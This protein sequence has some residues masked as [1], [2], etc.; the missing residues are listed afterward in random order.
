MNM[1]RASVLAG[2]CIAAGTTFAQDF[3]GEDFTIGAGLEAIRDW[4]RSQLTPNLVKQGRPWGSPTDPWLGESSITLDANGWPTMDAGMVFVSNQ[5][6]NDGQEGTYKIRFECATIPEIRPIASYGTVENVVRDTNTGIVTADY[7]YPNIN[8]QVMFGF[9][10]TNGGVRNLTIFRP[11]QDEA[12][13]FTNLYR[14]HIDR[15]SVLRFMDMNLI[16]NNITAHWSQRSQPS[17]VTWRTKTGIPYENSIALCNQVNSDY[18]LCIPHRATDDYIRQLARLVRDNLNPNLKV[19][20]EMSNEVWNTIYRQG[21]D[22]RDY[23]N[24]EYANNPAT[25]L[26]YDGSTNATIHRWRYYARRTKEMS[27]IFQDEFGAGSLNTRVRPLLCGQAVRDEQYR[28]M[29]QYIQDV[30]G[31]PNQWFHALG[32]GMYF[33]AWHVDNWPDVTVTDYVNELRQATTADIGSIAWWDNNISQ[34]RYASM[35]TWYR[36][37]P[38]VGYESG[39]DTRG[40]AYVDVKRQLYYD[41]RMRDLCNEYIDMWQRHGN[42][43][44]VWAIA[45]AGDW[46]TDS[47]AYPILETMTNPSTPRTQAIDDAMSTPRA[48]LTAGILV[49][50][51]INARK[52]VMRDPATWQNPAPPEEW[53]TGRSFDYLIRT[54]NAA[55]LPVSFVASSWEPDSGMTIWLNGQ[56]IGSQTFSNTGPQ[57]NEIYQ[58]H[59]S[60]NVSF[61]KGLS[62]LRI[63]SNRAGGYYVRELVVGAGGPTCDSIDFNN[64][65]SSFDPQDIDAFLSVYS[66]GPCIPGTATCNDIDFNNDSSVFDPCDISSF[67]LMYSEGPCTLCGV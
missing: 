45:G 24:A 14:N 44:L 38:V 46:N 15:F 2:L 23:A 1:R 62:T 56:Q 36:M 40:D 7:I 30:Y 6:L 3:P 16:N 64:D 28:I 33:W 39:P 34:E 65:T 61:P 4:T 5:P 67:L 43:T 29:L 59:G 41:P 54:D 53:I 21:R 8:F 25:N 37:A 10:G 42:G 22:Y 51:T 60:I 57:G 27:Q 13:D 47:G 48:P 32:I 19:Y 17:Q 18:Y 11:N 52:H 50:G 66:E 31:D 9:F 35:S 12:Q 55:T 58:T 26:A 49:P 20:V 63:V